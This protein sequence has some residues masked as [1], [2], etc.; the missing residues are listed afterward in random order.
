MSPSPNHLDKIIVKSDCYATSFGAVVVFGLII[1]VVLAVEYPEHTEWMANWASVLADFFVA[2]GVFG[3]IYFAKRGGKAQELLRLESNEKVA[4]ANSKAADAEN[5]ASDAILELVKFRTPRRTLLKGHE[6]RLTSILARYRG[7][8]FDS[9][10]SFPS[11][12]VTDFWWD[13]QPVLDKAGWN[14]LPWPNP[15]ASTVSQRGLAL[16]GQ[17]AATDVEIH[18]DALSRPMF[19]PAA[20]ALISALGDI[21]ITVVDMG[22]NNSHSFNTAIHIHIGDKS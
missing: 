2:V 8:P 18:I 7:T 20:A 21:G 17:V 22:C 14:H 19:G 4:E 10:L 11:A 3:E 13:L 9:G 12:E 6:V 16:S 15:G 1:E 5:R